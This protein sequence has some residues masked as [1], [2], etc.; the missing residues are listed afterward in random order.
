MT[1]N[2]AFAKLDMLVLDHR[3]PHQHRD[4]V[5]YLLTL[6]EPN[7]LDMIKEEIELVYDLY[8]K[9]VAKNTLQI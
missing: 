5:L 2:E 1:R 3:T 9:K 6:M 4:V 8:V 7:Q